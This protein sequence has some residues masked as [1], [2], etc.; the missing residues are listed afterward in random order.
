MSISSLWDWFS[1]E[2]RYVLFFAMAILMIV[3]IVKRAWI[4][5]VVSIIGLAFI[6]IFII[7]PDTILSLA[8]WLGNKLNLGG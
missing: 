2:I 3:C 4:M 7:N 8:E 1:T 5:L 6:G